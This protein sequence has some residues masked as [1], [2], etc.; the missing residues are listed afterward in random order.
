MINLTNG[1]LSQ[2]K[3]G[4]AMSDLPKSFREA[5][6]VARDWLRVR[7]LWIDSMC[8]VQDLREDWETEASRMKDVYKNAWATIAVT[9]AANFT[10]GCFTERNVNMVRP[11][12]VRLPYFRSHPI[13]NAECTYYCLD[14]QFWESEVKESPLAQRA[15]VVQER[16]LSRRVIHFGARQLLWECHEVD[17]CENFPSSIPDSII[18]ASPY[19]N[20]YRFKDM[21]GGG[22]HHD[23]QTRAFHTWGIIVRAYS[24]GKLSRSSDKA[25][26]LVGIADELAQR[27]NDIY[28]AGLWRRNIEYHLLWQASLEASRKPNLQNVA[29]SW[30]WLAV[31]GFV[32]PEESCSGQLLATIVDV[33]MGY[34]AEGSTSVRPNGGYLQLAG[35]L[36]RAKL[37][38]LLPRGKSRR[39]GYYEELL[40]EGE[41]LDESEYY[42]C[43]ARDD[44]TILW[45][46]ELYCLPVLR[47]ADITGLVL[48]SMGAVNEFM[49]VGYFV[50][51]VHGEYSPNEFDPIL[52]PVF[53][54]DIEKIITLV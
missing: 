34:S 43:T 20:G 42:I 6:V 49:R 44:R 35:I 16:L 50:L 8:I 25:I 9:R 7:Y 23:K 30:S 37:K 12:M 51:Q 18:K 29:P 38:R 52:R 19:I 46:D 36:W 39:A 11:F 33:K 47:R 40:L 3:C 26:A 2:F 48:I 32:V 28:L 53:E 10:E 21:T 15:W 31:D 1:N 24:R 13:N 22:S 4:I 27:F 45:P 17:S 14:A 54:S 5:I 41:Q